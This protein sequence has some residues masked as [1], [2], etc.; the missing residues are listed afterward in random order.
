MANLEKTCKK[1][2]PRTPRAVS[3]TPSRAKN[4]AKY[5]A[6]LMPI[7]KPSI[8][9]LVLLITCANS[10]FAGPYPRSWRKTTSFTQNVRSFFMGGDLWAEVS[11]DNVAKVQ[12]LLEDYPDMANEQRADGIHPI[13]L[14]SSAAMARVLLKAGVN[15]N[16]ST[17]YCC[18][19]LLCHA[20]R[21][22]LAVV[23]VLVDSG[24]N[25]NYRDERQRMTVVHY[26]AKGN[27]LEVVKAL[28]DAGANISTVTEGVYGDTPLETA[29]RNG[30]TEVFAYLLKQDP[31]T[32]I[33]KAFLIAS[34]FGRG[35]EFHKGNPDIVKLCLQAGA[36]IKTTDYGSTALHLAAQRFDYDVVELLLKKGAD[37]KAKDS[38]TTNTKTKTKTKSASDPPPPPRESEA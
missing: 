8:L 5:Q 23:K 27:H 36:N 3:Q 12:K 4:G 14:A 10:L 11:K 29:A 35:K 7:T 16:A 17:G 28:H 24:A 37:V 1:T 26:A 21:G 15:A 25:V 6:V 2:V 18:T 13:C 31:K 19:P 9:I 38:S 34:Q 32:K 30:A 20:S 22:N 33:D